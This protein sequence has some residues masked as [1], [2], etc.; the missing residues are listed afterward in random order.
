M[1]GIWSYRRFIW[2]TA[3][4]DLRYRYA[5]SGLGVFWNVLTPLAML[6]VYAV[7]FGSVFAQRTPSGSVAASAFV[8]YLSSGFLPWG[9]FVDCLT[10]TTNALVTNATYLRK[11]PIPEQVF[12]AQAASSAALGMLIAVGL[13][14]IA[15]L[16]LGQR[17][18]WTWIALPAIALL[19]QGFGFGLGLALG[20]LNAF[21][22]D[23]GQMLVVVLQIWMWSVPVV[24]PES[25]LPGVYRAVLP[26][27]P[28]Y[29][30]LV[31]FRSAYLDGSLAPA[32]AWAAMLVWGVLAITVGHVILSH[33]RAEVRDVL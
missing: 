20:T 18:M 5:G 9:A 32:W 11:M 30:F 6:V 22:R 16:A 27:N 8:L 24:Y 33:L 3:L 14:V 25:I 19:W 23:V 31:T 17:P 1:I 28:A 21:F 10:R 13:L 26:F 29:P 4:A 12:V 2:D 7:I 15:A